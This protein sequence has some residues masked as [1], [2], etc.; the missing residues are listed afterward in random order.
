MRDAAADEVARFAREH[1]GAVA[2]RNLADD[3][4]LSFATWDDRADRVAVGLAGLGVRPGD[5]VVLAVGPDEP[6]EW[7]VAPTPG[8]PAR[9]PAAPPRLPGGPP[10]GAP[11]CPRRHPPRAAGAP[12]DPRRRHARGDRGGS[13]RR[14]GR[15]VAR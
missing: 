2:W 8:H 11:R 15:S 14:R 5:R 9:G 3:A 4:E 10:G 13:P 7:L 1:P 12:R 6:L